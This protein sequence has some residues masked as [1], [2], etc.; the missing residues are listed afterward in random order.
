MT[1][2]IG[3]GHANAYKDNIGESEECDPV[4]QLPDEPA[5]A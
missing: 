4:G 1:H 3:H 5:P 2:K